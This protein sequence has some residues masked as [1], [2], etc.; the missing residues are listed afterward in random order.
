MHIATTVT[1]PI[2]EPTGTLSD[3]NSANVDE[4]D[5]DSGAD[6]AKSV[7]GVIF[8]VLFLVL[9]AATT[10][11]VV[12]YLVKRRQAGTSSDAINNYSFGINSI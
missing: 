1:V 4:S 12:I 7:V 3:S 5:V 2:K 10:V 6:I 8:G 9:T 11:I